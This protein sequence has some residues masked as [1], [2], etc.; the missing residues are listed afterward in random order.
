MRLMNLFSCFHGDGKFCLT[1]VWLID[2]GLG[3]AGLGA[4][5]LTSSRR[6][7]GSAWHPLPSSDRVFPSSQGRSGDGVFKDSSG[8]GDVWCE[9]LHNPGSVEALRS[10]PGRRWR[11]NQGQTAKMGP[12][13][14]QGGRYLAGLVANKGRGREGL[15]AS[16]SLFWA[17]N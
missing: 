9:L 1:S 4:A 15:R 7:G 3:R 5:G 8:P 17:F 16:V 10:S 14:S 11:R 13:W 12:S 2:S 6:S